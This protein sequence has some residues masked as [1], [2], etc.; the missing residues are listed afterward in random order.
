MQL[1]CKVIFTGKWVKSLIKKQEETNL[2]FRT[3]RHP[4]PYLLVGFTADPQ[5]LFALMFQLSG[6]SADGLVQGVDL[7]VQVG[8]AVAAGTN[9]RLQVRDPRQE[10]LF[11]DKMCEK[12]G[13]KDVRLLLGKQKKRK[14]AVDMLRDSSPLSYLLVAVLHGVLQ[15]SFGSV[16]LFKVDLLEVLYGCSMEVVEFCPKRC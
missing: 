13:E 11:L 14:I 8:D 2:D 15:L 1:N 7:V 10:L 12:R 6:Q 9:V 5:H 3:F 16:V 4:L